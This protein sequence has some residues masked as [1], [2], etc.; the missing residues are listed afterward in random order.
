V[1]PR[2]VADWRWGLDR[3]GC[4]RYPSMRLIR[5]SAHGDW[6]EPMSR[7]AEAL[8]RLSKTSLSRES[9]GC[10]NLSRASPP[11]CN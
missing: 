7:V 6:R 3:E 9:P 5:Q 2:Q 4:P 1:L 10:E 11:E 8:Q